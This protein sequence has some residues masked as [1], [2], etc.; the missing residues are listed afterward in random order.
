MSKDTKGKGKVPE[1]KVEAPTIIKCTKTQR[2]LFTTK[3][4]GYNEDVKIIIDIFNKVTSERLGII[5]DN[6]IE[7]LKID[8]V[9]EDWSFDQNSIQFTKTVKPEKK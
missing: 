6:F 1:T 2:E 7:E 3:R 5:V 4:N 9:N 8:V